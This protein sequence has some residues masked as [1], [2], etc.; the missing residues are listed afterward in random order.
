MLERFYQMFESVYRY[1]QDLNAYIA[2]MID[3]VF[4]DHTIESVLLHAEGKQLF[5]EAVYLYGLMLLQVCFRSRF[6]ALSLS[7]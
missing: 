5:A 1:V 3:G 6:C 7:L 2:E 4:V